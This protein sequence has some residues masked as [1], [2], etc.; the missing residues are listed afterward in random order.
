MEKEINILIKKIK[1]GVKLDYKELEN[2]FSGYLSGE[3]NDQLMTKVLKEICRCELCEEN[4]FD[5]TDIF[6]KSGDTFSVNEDFIDKHST[7]GVGDKTTL[8]VLPI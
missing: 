4:I 1:K 5:L 7:G 2:V 8:I 6:I 3:V